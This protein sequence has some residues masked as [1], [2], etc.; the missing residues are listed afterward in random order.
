[1][2]RRLA[3]L[4]L[5]AA[6]GRAQEYERLLDQARR[7]L[8]DESLAVDRR[9]EAQYEKLAEA[10]LKN[11]QRWEA[12]FERGINRCRSAFF[13]HSAVEYFL[14][15]ARAA[16]E[17]E[18]VLARSR[19][20]AGQQIGRWIAEARRDFGVAEEVMRRR[21][22]WRPDHEH[23][24]FANAAMKFA[25]REYLKAHQGKP[26]AIEDFKEL[27]RRNFLPDRCA[28]HIA[29]CYMDLGYDAY[30]RE[31]LEG[32]QRYLDEAL[33]WARQPRLRETLWTNKAGVHGVANEHAL[34]EK[35][36]RTLVAENPDRPVHHKN[37]GLS[38]GFQNRLK[39]ALYYYD[40]ARELCRKSGDASLMLANGNA[41]IR[42]AVI[43]AKL[44]ETDGDVLLAWR[45]FLEYREVFGDDYNFSLWFGDVAAALGA[46]DVSWR[47]LE[48]ARQLQPRCPVP[49][50]M[51][52]QIAPRTQGTPEEVMARIEMA[53]EAYRE[54]EARYV[55]KQETVAM[56]RMC[57]GLGDLGDVGAAV[58][59][60]TLLDP[61]PLAGADADHP[62]EWILKVAGARDPFVP[63]E[64][65]SAAPV[66]PAPADGGGG[67]AAT[68][69]APWPL[70]IAAVAGALL[71]AGAGLF[72]FRRRPA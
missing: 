22:E 9:L 43:H 41:W 35:V 70:V 21:G 24:L 52:V 20:A 67:P 50:Q 2:I 69:P 25:G 51:L 4:L 49:Y 19:A 54:A 10:A 61:D 26:G 45:L 66:P 71:V 57:S 53:K 38:L 48:R 40:R 60:K 12:H 23:L 47:Y 56:G 28:D 64:P 18:E 17:S 27:I 36:L 39:E 7:I 34:S 3:V 5:L 63:F 31:D 44:L 46:Y 6:A 59:E 55:A 15:R 30:I 13:G 16:G 58:V 8:D 14:A 68:A 42:A 33:K 62:P 32:A 11:P 37:L 72:V 65:A 29:L 1:V